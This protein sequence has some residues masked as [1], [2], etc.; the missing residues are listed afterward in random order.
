MPGAGQWPASN[1]C[2]LGQVGRVSP[3]SVNRPPGLQ[4]PAAGVPIPYAALPASAD[5]FA[6]SSFMLGPMV[7]LIA[8]F[9][10]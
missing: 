2:S 3:P 5:S 6:T 9:S 7:E 4:A 10:T 8:A 1:P